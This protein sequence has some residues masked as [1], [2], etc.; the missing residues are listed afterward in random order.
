[1]GLLSTT[2]QETADGWCTL[3]MWQ[4]QPWFIVTKKIEI[5]IIS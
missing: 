1:M 2:E 4:C 3:H 5:Q